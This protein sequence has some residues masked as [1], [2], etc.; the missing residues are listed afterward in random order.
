MSIL[1]QGLQS[2]KRSIAMSMKDYEKAVQR[3]S[4]RP[5]LM[6][7]VGPRPEE[8]VRQAEQILGLVFPPTYRRFLLEYGAGGYGYIE[9]YGIVNNEDLT[10][11]G[12]PNGI[13][14]TLDER[15]TSQLPPSYVVIYNDGEGSLA[16][17]DCSRQG[18][19]APVI[20]F[21][22]GRSYNPGDKLMS[23]F[24]KFFYWLVKLAQE[25]ED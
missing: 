6:D 20:E 5:D 25:V 8:V 7:F 15:T 1:A 22:P 3:M 11:K 9:I 18:V 16:C 13:W 10:V 23:D 24:G 12:V 21:T 2:N 4:K 17:L 19:E 14:Y